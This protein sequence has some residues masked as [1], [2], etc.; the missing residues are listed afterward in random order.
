VLQ[1]ENA[2]E[3]IAILENRPDVELVFTDIMMPGT[4]DGQKLVHY[5]RER[6]PPIQLMS[7]QG[8]QSLVSASYPTE[9]ASP[10]SPAPSK[11]SSRRQTDCCRHFEGLGPIDC[12]VLSI[13]PE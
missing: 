7:L 8:R 4:M 1:A 5:I 6:W 11:L 2:D 13:T 3:V 10:P 12:A 9:R